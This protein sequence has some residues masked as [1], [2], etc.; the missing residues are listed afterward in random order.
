L[1]VETSHIIIWEMKLFAHHGVLPQERSVGACFILNLRI[2]TDFSRAME[3]DE[4]DG[5]LSY[6]SV[7]DVV[8]EEM[9]QPSNLL[10]HVAGRICR[11]L[12]LHFPQAEAIQLELLKENP[13]MG[14]DCKGAGVSLNVRRTEETDTQ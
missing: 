9:A 14:A 4:L 8:K 11:S 2:E 10:E 12:F 5:T 7:Y 13:P 6:A 3:S 1:K